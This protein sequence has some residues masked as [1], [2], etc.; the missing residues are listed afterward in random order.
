MQIV[1]QPTPVSGE[2]IDDQVAELLQAGVNISID[3]DDTAN[4]LTIASPGS[5][6]GEWV[7]R[8]IDIMVDPGAGNFRI[9]AASFALTTSFAISITTDGGV[10]AGNVLGA[11]QVGDS[12]YIQEKV[13]SA[14][15]ARYTIDSIVNNTS[16]YLFA[17]TYVTGGT[18]M[19][20]NAFA[21]IIQ[22][23]SGGGGGG[24]GYTD[25]QAQDAVGLILVD[26]STIDF[27]YNDAGPSITANLLTGSVTET[28]IQLSD[29]TADNADTTKH[30]FL[31]KLSGN[32]TQ[33]LT[34]AGTWVTPSGDAPNNA[35]YITGSTNAILTAERVLT[36]TATIAWDKAT[37]GQMKAN[38]LSGSVTETHI[39]LS[40]LTA[41]NASTLQHGFLPKLSGAATQYLDGTGA[42][43]IPPGGVTDFL[44]LSDT[45]NSYA[46]NA[47]SMVRVNPGATALEFIA[48]SNSTTTTITTS[49]S[50]IA[51]NSGSGAAADAYWW[52]DA[53]PIQHGCYWQVPSNYAGGDVTF[54]FKRRSSVTGTATMYCEGFRHRNN[55]SPLGVLGPI[56]YNFTAS[57]NLIYEDTVVL[58]SGNVQVGDTVKFNLIR[59]GGNASDTKTGHVYNDGMAVTYTAYVGA[60]FGYPT[61]L[62][63]SDTP[64]TYT[65]NASKVLRV[66]AAANAT[67]FG[68]A[69]G[70]M[71]TQHA[72]AVAITGGS[73]ALGG[74]TSGLA[75]LVL[76]S[77]QGN[78]D[79][80]LAW[81]AQRVYPHS[82][83]GS[84]VTIAGITIED[85][86]LTG[87]S[88]CGGYRGFQ[89]L[90]PT[91]PISNQCYA[92]RGLIAAG[93]N[94]YNC[95]M[96][97]TAPNY[98]AGTVGMQASP[99]S[100]RAITVA[101]TASGVQYGIQVQP[102]TDTNAKALFFT[103]ASG[104][105]V[106][107]ISTTATATAYS[108]SSDIRL[109]TAITPITG[110]LERITSLNPIRFLWK[111]TGEEGHGFAAHELQQ[112]V[113]EAVT[114]EP[115]ALNE[116][117]SIKPQQVD[118]SKLVPWLVGALQEL[119]AKYDALLTR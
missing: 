32:M 23:G 47:N 11:I 10:N 108:T 91:I 28:H 112:V 100:A 66:N 88:T 21:A 1:V 99:L 5:L 93:A 18:G 72:N 30:G 49:L 25:E 87:G 77:N 51:L 114:G 38:L 37:A 41:D 22:F 97:G 109:K 26:S 102:S 52:V 6:T 113:P 62:S 106:G 17:V 83:S 73:V 59:D 35:E 56:Q 70:T 14:I 82:G 29:S 27:T 117:G 85:P 12:L 111:S 9:N 68:D 79:N 55:A 104:A 20:S 34:G 13:D 42:W 76:S 98:F 101:Y 103:N 65:G 89:V 7:Y 69:L 53:L 63:L 19:I 118:F 2:R 95:Y 16:W 3:Y 81:T 84:N 75:Q 46:S 15:W 74:A 96:E 119:S 92:F 48:P 44:G 43:T 116:D 24:T 71:A 57:D 33:V 110:A 40:D 58:A 60:S 115:N 54:H 94:R 45:P 61:L 39:Q 107:S 36:D 78:S 86:T 8:N 105:E 50:W 90:N 64:D 31:P 4:T 80:P 67:E